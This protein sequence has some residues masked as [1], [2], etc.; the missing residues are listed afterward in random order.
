M[1]G[2]DA[3]LFSLVFDT[4]SL[5]IVRATLGKRMWSH[6]GALFI[7]VAVIYHG[8]GEVTNRIFPNGLERQFV[9]RSS[10]DA[11]MYIVGPGILVFYRGLPGGA[12][13]SQGYPT[14]RPA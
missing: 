7:V 14:R 1:T 3:L 8:V 11:W 2:F 4:A 12:W 9:P 13:Q 5:V 6:V 10:L